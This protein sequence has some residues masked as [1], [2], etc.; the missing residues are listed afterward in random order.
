MTTAKTKTVETAPKA[1]RPLVSIDVTQNTWDRCHRD[2]H[3]KL[4][5]AITECPNG[6]EVG[7]ISKLVADLRALELIEPARP[8]PAPAP[9]RKLS[10]EEARLSA[11]RKEQ[12]EAAADPVKMQAFNRKVAEREKIEA[13]KAGD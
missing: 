4:A 12:A 9:E 8:I 1:P 2:L 13:A 3:K 6:G 10:P 5:H 7:I 11:I